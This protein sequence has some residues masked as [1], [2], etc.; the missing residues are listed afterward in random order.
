[1]SHQKIKA[2]IIGLGDI[3]QKAYLP[4]L[5][6]HT[7][8]DLM[9]YNRSPE[10]LIRI[11]NQYRIESG[12]TSLEE[13]INSKPQAA[14]V[15]TS[16]SSHFNIVKHLLENEIDV[17]VEKPATLNSWE[18]EELAEL[19]DKNNRILM[20]GFNRRFAP[21]HVKMKK[22]WGDTLVSMGIFQKFRT[23]AAHPSLKHQLID[24]TIHQVDILRF[25]CGDGR[26]DKITQD[27]VPGSFLGAVGTVRL[28][29]GGIGVIATNMK[30][31]RWQERYVLFGGQKTLQ[32]EA[33]S[34]AILTQGNEQC[35]WNETY[36][37]SWQTTLKGRGF[38]DEIEHFFEC[39]ETRRTPLTSAWDSVKTQRLIEEIA[40]L[41]EVDQN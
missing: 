40:D 29:N 3:A 9:L 10:P 31:G 36:A 38:V 13:V 5:T 39:L 16:S 26:V 18:T 21:L 25:Y 41:G 1:M 19:A 15:L 22:A 24:D 32:V 30:A 12:T 7:A 33:F 20:V 23:S 35:C 28:D 14:F 34:E 17:F 6:S 11:Q 4:I 8:V 27:T 2:A 37:S